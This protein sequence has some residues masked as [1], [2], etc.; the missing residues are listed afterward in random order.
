MITSSSSLSVKADLKLTGLV[1]H[2]WH[3]FTSIEFCSRVYTSTAHFTQNE[4]FNRGI[5][6][7]IGNDASRK[8][9]AQSRSLGIL[10]KSLGILRSL[11]VDKSLSLEF[12]WF[13]SQN[14]NNC[15]HY[16]AISARSSQ[17]KEQEKQVL[18]LFL[19][20]ATHKQH[21]V[22]NHN[23]STHLR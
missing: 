22:M 12:L 21:G 20:I 4:C 10:K 14:L 7:S 5:E 13:G 2:W 8:I 19:W 11:H 18:G 23:F 1:S 6:W 3:S 16:K 9:S 15:T 17:F